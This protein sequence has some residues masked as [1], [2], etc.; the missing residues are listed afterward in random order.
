MT[1]EVSREQML[2][3]SPERKRILEVLGPPFQKIYED[4][5]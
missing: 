5:A 4:A 1:G 2:N 3:L